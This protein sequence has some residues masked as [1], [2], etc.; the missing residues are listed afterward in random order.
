MLL[1][2]VRLFSPSIFLSLISLRKDDLQLEQHI[3]IQ[4]P[5][6]NQLAQSNNTCPAYSSNMWT[7]QPNSREFSH[8]TYRAEAVQKHNIPLC[9]LRQ[10]Y[11]NSKW[12]GKKNKTN[13]L[14]YLP[15]LFPSAI[16]I[17]SWQRY[18]IFFWCVVTLEKP[19]ET[20]GKEK[21]LLQHCHSVATIVLHTIIRLKMLPQIPNKLNSGD[22]H[23]FFCITRT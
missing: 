15:S 14:Q 11:F 1:T 6:L 23:L 7:K 5:Q 21:V 13:K 8:F 12:E 3:T 18:T 22:D 16:L 9:K 17:R 19:L 4:T 2:K 20:A 10:S